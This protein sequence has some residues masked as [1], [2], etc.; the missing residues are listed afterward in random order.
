MNIRFAAVV[1]LLLGFSA[2][3]ITVVA[4]HGY[5]GF[6]D[7]A[8]REPWAMQM[9]LDL[10]IALSIFTGWM[11]RDARVRGI[12]AW[13]YV[14]AIVTLGS[15]GAIAYLVHRRIA[16]SRALASTGDRGRA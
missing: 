13:P 1:T 16:P 7:V 2:Y 12:T 5:T 11:V 8:A 15:I 6:L 4:A 10:V 14:L 3:S 9:L